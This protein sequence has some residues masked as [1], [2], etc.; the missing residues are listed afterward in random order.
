M[1][2][3][4]V[5]M[6]GASGRMGREIFSVIGENKELV[7]TLAISK[8]QPVEGWKNSVIHWKNEK[9]LKSLNLSVCIDFSLP[10]A[11]PEVVAFCKKYKLP[12]VCGTTGITEK[13]FSELKKL[14]KSVPVLWSSNMSLGI[15]T[16]HKM[17]ECFS[18]L[19]DFDFQIE[20]IHHNKKKDRPS[21]TALSLQKTLNKVT[22]LKNP[23]PV[24]I[25]GGGVFGVHKI[26]AISDEEVITIEHTALNRK[27]FAKGALTASRW[28]V[29]QKPGMYSI[30][31]MFEKIK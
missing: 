6:F 7:P 2:K 14:S 23:E 5:A 12:L 16:V 19:K 25:R 1:A 31:S 27:V 24:A 15:A 30:N 20:E 21:G 4:N 18:N 9:N 26:F 29:K 28:I 8:N 10:E 13:D 11:L 17:M 22:E 3:L